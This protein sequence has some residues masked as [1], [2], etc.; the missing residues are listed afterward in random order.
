LYIQNGPFWLLDETY[1]RH[2]NDEKQGVGPLRKYVVAAALLAALS[3]PAWA[4]ETITY[5]YD[6]LGR[7]VK[8]VHTGTVNNNQQTVY[9]ND[10]ADNR[11]N[12]TTTGAPH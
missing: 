7:L 3:S 1:R 12:V 2:Q 11:T 4:S 5:T 10:P 8:V 9:T 6:A